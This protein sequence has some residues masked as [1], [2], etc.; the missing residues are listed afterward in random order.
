MT[1]RRLREIRRA[2]VAVA[3]E[4]QG[5]LVALRQLLELGISRSAVRAEVQAGRWRRR[6]SKTFAVDVDA[7]PMMTRWWYAVL[8]SGRTAALD[9]VTA[10]AYAGMTGFEESDLHVSVPRFDNRHSVGGVRIHNINHRLE[11]ELC[12]GE[13]AVVR[14]EIAA[15]RGAAWA[16]S[17][18]QAALVLVMPVQQRIVTGEALLHAAAT[19]GVRARRDFI[20]RMALDIA[21]GAE[22]LGELDFAALCRA[23]EIAE[24]DRQVVRRGPDGRIYLD[25]RWPCG[26]VVEIDGIHHLAGL[27]PVDDALR[28]NSVTLTSDTVLRIPLL[29]LRLQPGRF[30]RQVRA[31]L[32][33]RDGGAVA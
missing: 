10:L 5:G 18:R 8:E 6:G 15:I 16:M 1:T 25:V 29:G 30:M 20:E 9:G 13:P 22:S 31:G 21:D 26:L 17:D 7:D 24:P 23:Y 11:D 3:A 12:G 19:I 4:R 33:L 27:N 14:P 32:A 28:Q 2:E